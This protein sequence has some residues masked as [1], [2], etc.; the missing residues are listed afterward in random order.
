MTDRIDDLIRRLESVA[1]KETPHIHGSIRLDYAVFVIRS[2]AGEQPVPPLCGGCKGTGISDGKECPRC[3]GSG[4]CYPSPQPPSPDLREAARDCLTFNGGP[5]DGIDDIEYVM[6][7]RCDMDALDKAI[8]KQT[9]AIDA[10]RTTPQP[11]A[12]EL[13]EQVAELIRELRQDSAAPVSAIWADRILA[14]LRPEPREENRQR[15]MNGPDGPVAPPDG[16][17]YEE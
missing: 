5:I 13:R 15:A 10:A 11:V 2:W 1:N 8:V 4:I 9:D 16:W 17:H 6:V 14:L 7:R 12:G 3:E